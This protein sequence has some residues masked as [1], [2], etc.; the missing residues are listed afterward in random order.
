MATTLLSGLK[1][2]R[3]MN[4]TSPMTTAKYIRTQWT[5]PTDIFSIL[6]L[7]APNIIQHAVAQL[8]GR[9]VTPVAFSFGWVAYSMNALLAVVGDGRLMPKTE[10]PSIM[11]IDVQTGHTRMNE[12]WIIGQ[13]FRVLDN[14]VDTDMRVEQP[15]NPSGMKSIESG[16]EYPGRP[17][18]ALRI[19]VFETINEPCHIHGIPSKD[20]VWFSGF[21]VI[22]LQLLIATIP[23]ILH[24][25]WGT[26]LITVYGNVLALLH[27]SLQQWKDEKWVC[28]KSGGSSVILTPGNGSRHVILIRGTKGSVA[29]LQLNK[30][31]LFVIVTI[32]S[33][34]NLAVAGAMRSPSALGVHIRDTR[35]PLKGTSVKGVLRQAEELYPGAGVLLANVFF[36]GSMRVQQPEFA[37][38]RDAQ[39]RRSAPNKFGARIDNLSALETNRHWEA[40]DGIRALK[41]VGGEVAPGLPI[42][43]AVTV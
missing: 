7:L 30:W 16:A 2:P 8:A 22:T 5:N 32:G 24:Y 6:Q 10:S 42:A 18:E 36:P 34:Q 31:Y 33:L 27:G 43:K 25:E 15:H 3:S 35:K 17:W 26:M 23:V 11:V 37:F 19:S 9:R 12:S 20:L 40:E 39:Q 13:L 14:D 1:I 28:P 4:I 21:I 29:G 38:W 41:E